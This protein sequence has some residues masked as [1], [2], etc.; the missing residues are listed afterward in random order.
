M[1]SHKTR[2]VN[3]PVKAINDLYNVID[4]LQEQIKTL[5]LNKPAAAPV[6]LPKFT[7]K[8][9]KDGEI[10]VFNAKSGS[11]ELAKLE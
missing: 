2:N 10:F 6:N 7:T 5:S 11:F 3:N 4:D 9:P 1:S 8:K